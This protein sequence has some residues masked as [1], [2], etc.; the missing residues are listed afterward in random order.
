M[1]FKP[2]KIQGTNVLE[3]AWKIRNSE[4]GDSIR[5]KVIKTPGELVW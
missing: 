1:A 5:K 2:G 3:T 4:E